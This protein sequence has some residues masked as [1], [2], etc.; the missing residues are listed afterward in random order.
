M[1][2][3]RHE[4]VIRK[5]ESFVGVGHN[6]EIVQDEAGNDWIFYHG[7]C[8]ENTSGRSLFLDK[9]VW[10]DDWPTVIGGLPSVEL[11]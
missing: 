2:E 9:I 8:V 1:I 11:C 5:N 10:V 3:N 7:F 6:S 4:T